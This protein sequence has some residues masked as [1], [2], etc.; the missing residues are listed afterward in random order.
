VKKKKKIHYPRESLQE[1][2]RK[3][4]CLGG[5]FNYEEDTQVK[6]EHI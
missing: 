4:R 1:E 3:R 2:K 5:T 6:E